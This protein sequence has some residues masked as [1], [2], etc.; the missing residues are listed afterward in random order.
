MKYRNTENAPVV[1]FD[2]CAAYA[3]HGSTIAVELGIRAMTPIAGESEGEVGADTECHIAGRLRCGL[4]A[5]K[6]LRDVLDKMIEK[7]ERPQVAAAA[8]LGKLN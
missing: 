5:A 6:H 4:T 7:M 1:Y 8:M 3:N 2:F